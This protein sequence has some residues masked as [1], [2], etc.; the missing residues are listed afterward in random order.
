[1]TIELRNPLYFP[2]VDAEELIGNRGLEPSI[3]VKDPDL[4]IQLQAALDLVRLYLD[5]L[6]V[7]REEIYGDD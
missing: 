4:A 7:K 3:L 5:A 1:M 6:V 2:F